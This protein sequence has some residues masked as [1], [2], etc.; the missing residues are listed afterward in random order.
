MLVLEQHWRLAAACRSAEPDIFFPLSSSGRSLDQIDRAKEV[1]AGC[2]VR[3][4]CLAF[5]LRTNQVHGVWGGLTEEERLS[6]AR[7]ALRASA[8]AKSHAAVPGAVS[9]QSVIFP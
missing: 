3:A 4:E 2:R 8:S 5:A 1:C 6:L 9:G 7:D